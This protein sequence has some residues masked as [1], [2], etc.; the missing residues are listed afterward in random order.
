MNLLKE[1]DQIVKR[2]GRIEVCR[3]IRTGLS[4]VR[5]CPQFG[6]VGSASRKWNMQ[7]KT[8][9]SSAAIG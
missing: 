2:I 7:S 6:I 8:W 4:H 9:E 3:Q 1:T 5:T